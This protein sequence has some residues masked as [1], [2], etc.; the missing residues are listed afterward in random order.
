MIVLLDFVV[1]SIFADIPVDKGYVLNVASPDDM[2]S[3]KPSLK[4]RE[5]K[6]KK[7]NIHSLNFQLLYK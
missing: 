1:V 2:I 4:E 6:K 3:K 7:L 5:A